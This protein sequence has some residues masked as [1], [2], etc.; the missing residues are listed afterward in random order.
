[1][2]E[3]HNDNFERPTITTEDLLIDV[4]SLREDE[5][6][7]RAERNIYKLKSENIPYLE[8][9]K[10]API[11]KLVDIHNKEKVIEYALYHFIVATMSFANV[12]GEIR[13]R[14]LESFDR[15][16]NVKDIVNKYDKNI[17]NY[18]LNEKMDSKD[19]N[20]LTWDYESCS[21]FMWSLGLIDELDFS[22]EIDVDLISKI[23]DY[24]DFESLNK[25]SK[26]REKSEIMEM[27]D[28]C[29][30]YAWAA[31]EASLK[32]ISVPNLNFTVATYREVAFNKLLNFKQQKIMKDKININYK[33]DDFDFNFTIPSYLYIGEFKM[34]EK[35]FLMMRFDSRESKFSIQMFDLGRCKLDEFKHRYEE[36][37]SCTT[38]AVGYKHIHTFEKTLDFISSPLY[39]D[40]R[41][42]NNNDGSIYYFSF[43]FILNNKLILMTEA[44]DFNVD[45]NNKEE[46]LNH[47]LNSETY[48]IIS[49][50]KVNEVKETKVTDFNNTYESDTASDSYEI[51]VEPTIIKNEFD[52]SNVVPSLEKI[53][54]IIEYC[55]TVYNKF[56]LLV[57]D[58]EKR[59]DKL[60]LDYQTWDFKKGYGTMFDINVY[61]E[62]HD[63]VTCKCFKEFKSLVDKGN[64]KNITDLKINLSLDYRAGT[65]D[66]L[67]THENS[68]QINFKP[69]DIKF[70]RK[71]N[72]SDKIMS[73]IE[74][75]IN[76]MFNSFEKQDTIFCSK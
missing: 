67:T 6:L 16:Y 33:H 71:S 46:I 66:D 27:A 7:K 9:M 51:D 2:E 44:I 41:E 55:D 25:I 29:S 21:V 5:D 20:Q 47:A 54:E 40:V 60:K 62:N 11:N 13:N 72:F 64:V 31:R 19:L 12:P 3:Q 69:Y 65:Y 17:L 34:S 15:K 18:I 76:K 38:K 74:S 70:V 73:E 43:Y 75:N 37:K 56:L 1:M 8:D 42:A 22:K 14:I 48:K 23:L 35:D 53:T 45:I 32:K 57:A 10:S 28:L 63:Y 58:D 68:F 50:I 49:T 61:Y 30:R 59:N 26:L 52:Y 4:N 24:N 36:Q 39:V